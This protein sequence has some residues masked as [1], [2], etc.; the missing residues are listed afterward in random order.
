MNSTSSTSTS[1]LDMAKAA[2]LI[3][4]IGIFASFLVFL[5]LGFAMWSAED[6]LTKRTPALVFAVGAFLSVIAA[7]AMFARHVLT[8]TGAKTIMAQ[9][10]YRVKAATA[11]KDEAYTA[12]VM[13]LNGAQQRPMPQLPAHKPVRLLVNDRVVN[14]DLYRTQPQQQAAQPVRDWM[15]P[16]S[17]GVDEDGLLRPQFVRVAQRQKV[18]MPV[19]TVDERRARILQLSVMIYSRCRMRNPSRAYVESKLGAAGAANPLMKSNGDHTEAMAE[20]ERQ[21]RAWRDRNSKTAP[22]LWVDESTGEP[23][24]LG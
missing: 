15:A 14:A 24:D 6:D 13:R 5:M 10:E 8:E 12:T 23:I 2:A 20:L 3:A 11:S 9:A 4:L 17:E 16:K 7:I 1:Y 19:E 21:G 22:W 18:D